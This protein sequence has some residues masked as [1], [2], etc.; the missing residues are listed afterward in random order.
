MGFLDENDSLAYSA[1]LGELSSGLSFTVGFFK[2][3]CFLSL[4]A[5]FRGAWRT[6]LAT[7]WCFSSLKKTKYQ[8]IIFFWLSAL[9][10][11]DVPYNGDS[12][13]TLDRVHVEYVLPEGAFMSKTVATF[14][15]KVGL[16]W[17]KD[18]FLLQLMTQM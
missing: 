4:F 10:L 14:V 2:I 9:N 3:L 13:R 8:K 16:I 5:F 7:L 15:Q 11:K 6:Y 18:G 17:L 1:I 12:Y